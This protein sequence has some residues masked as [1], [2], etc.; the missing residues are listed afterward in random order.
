MQY[1]VRRFYY[2][3]FSNSVDTNL[4]SPATYSGQVALFYGEWSSQGLLQVYLNDR[5]G[6]VCSEF[7]TQSTADA[8]CQQLGYTNALYYTTYSK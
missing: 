5:W 2:L 8:A 6:T 1:S 3:L 7:F 4:T